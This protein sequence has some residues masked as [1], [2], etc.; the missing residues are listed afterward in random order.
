MNGLKAADLHAESRTGWYTSPCVF[1]HNLKK[2][3]SECKCKKQKQGGDGGVR[4][5]LWL[6]EGQVCMG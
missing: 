1:H 4:F 3:L 6:L 2:S 5:R